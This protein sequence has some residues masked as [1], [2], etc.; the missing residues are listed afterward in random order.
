VVRETYLRSKGGK[1]ESYLTKEAAS[2]KAK[3]SDW[4]LRRARER[5]K[6]RIERDHDFG[7]AKTWWLLPEAIREDS[8]GESLTTT[9]T[10]TNGENEAIHGGRGGEDPRANQHKLSQRMTSL[11]TTSTRLAY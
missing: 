5:L 1:A 8:L 6:V 7:S 4:A 9:T 3:I 2:S 11:T 10:N